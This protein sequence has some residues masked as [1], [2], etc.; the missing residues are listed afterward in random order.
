MSMFRE[1]DK[2][3]DLA[4]TISNSADE[5]GKLSESAQDTEA[6]KVISVYIKHYM[7]HKYICMRF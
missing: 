5:L 2:L 3:N 6:I 7:L 4:K 1:I